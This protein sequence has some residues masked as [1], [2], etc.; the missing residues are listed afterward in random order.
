MLRKI[1]DFL[2]LRKLGERDPDFVGL[3]K[4]KEKQKRSRA[5]IYSKTKELSFGVGKVRAVDILPMFSAQHLLNEKK[6]ERF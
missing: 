2:G 5:Y 3:R 6:N 1:G 4:Q